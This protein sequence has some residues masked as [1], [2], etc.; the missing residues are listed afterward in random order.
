MEQRKKWIS[1]ILLFCLVGGVIYCGINHPM[2][3]ED[4]YL[5]E[6]NVLTVWYTEET[7]QDYMESAALAYQEENGVKVKTALVSG[8]EYV[9]AINTATVQT[10]TGPDVYV[11]SSD[12]LE[13][14]YMTNLASEVTDNGIVLNATQFP[15]TALDAVTYHNRYVGYPLYF[16]TSFLLY[17]RTLLEQM[18]A[19]AIQQE[20][21]AAAGEEAMDEIAENG[22]GEEDV[23]AT[24][25]EHPE[26][27]AITEEEINE[28]V[29]LMIPESFT[30]IL[31]V[32]S[33]Y[34]LPEGV[35]TMFKWDISDVFYNYPFAGAYMNV[36]GVTGDNRESISIYNDSAM[37]CLSIYQDMNQFFS[38]EADEVS[39]DE[40][41]NEFMQGKI[42]FTIATTDCLE[43]MKAAAAE[44]QFSYT[45]GIIPMTKVNDSLI[46]RGLSMTG[47]AA[48][49][50]YSENKEAAN[51]FAQFLTCE[52][53]KNLYT[54]AGKMPS[55]LMESYP[56]AGMEEIVEAYANSVSLPKF[57]EAANYWILAEMCYTNI[58]QGADVNENL[59]SLSEQVKGQIYGE[60]YTEEVL[61]TPEVIE[62]Y[63]QE[64]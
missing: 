14:A 59:K 45:Y 15:Q 21:D 62:E 58:W 56:I 1:V 44:D 19:L 37:Y 7:L 47:V 24:A 33:G 23:A 28:R 35:E 26:N 10:G 5:K 18:A 34:D 46:S 52:Y 54:R 42:L 53:S 31:T 13:K 27:A 9:E 57:V 63:N 40:I 43:T 4:G 51:D 16:E 30:D 49:N 32:A 29:Q 11:I 6:Q 2:R 39:Y 25:A 38:I 61:P 50:G 48:V 12:S 60:L 17:N 8:L 20:R 55:H 41:L 3:T 36:G 64:E 22:T